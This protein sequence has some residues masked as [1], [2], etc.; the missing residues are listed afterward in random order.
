MA[1]RRPR[2]RSILLFAVKFLVFVAVLVVVWWTL[3]PYYGFVLAQTTG[4]TLRWVMQMP[5]E[6]ARVEP[7]GF[8]NTESHLVLGLNDGT[9]LRTRMMPIAVLITNVPP[10]WAL[11]LATAGLALRR[12]LKIL[13]WGTGIL[14]AGHYLFIVVASRFGHVMQGSELITAIAQFN[15]TLPFLLWIVF[16]YRLRLA[17]YFGDTGAKPAPPKD[18]A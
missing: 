16:A 7:H 10:Y 1:K 3:L 12:R 4:A 11:V 9:A 5:L 15:L 17:A 18:R 14:M 8:L 6:F 2:K 13:L